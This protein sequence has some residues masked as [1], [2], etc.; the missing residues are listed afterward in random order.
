MNLTNQGYFNLIIHESSPEGL[1]ELF[2]PHEPGEYYSRLDDVEKALTFINDMMNSDVFL[3]IHNAEAVAK[4]KPQD[5]MMK[6]LVLE[7]IRFKILKDDWEPIFYPLP[8]NPSEYEN[9][10]VIPQRKWIAVRVKDDNGNFAERNVIH[11]H[12]KEASGGFDGYDEDTRFW[13]KWRGIHLQNSSF[14]DLL[15]SFHSEVEEQEDEYI[16]DQ[17]GENC[18]ELLT[19]LTREPNSVVDKDDLDRVTD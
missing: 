5:L 1:E 9:P 14:V 16:A 7:R 17:V 13:V 3:N 4:V 19:A 11:F 15:N 10:D 12:D 2:V 18:M 8:T 6:G